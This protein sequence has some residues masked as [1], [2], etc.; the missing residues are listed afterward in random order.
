MPPE[1]RSLLR[2]FD[3]NPDQDRQL[4][5]DYLESRDAV[6]QTDG[7]PLAQEVEL[8]DVFADL[9]ELARVV[10]V[11]RSRAVVH[12]A[13]AQDPERADADGVGRPRKP[14]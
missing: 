2:G 14:Q 8:I 9:A 1:L 13:A 5:D 10:R 7:P 11:V 12:A 4:L 3:V 6:A